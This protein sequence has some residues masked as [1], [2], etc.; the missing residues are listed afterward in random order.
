M[1]ENTTEVQAIQNST[2]PIRIEASLI[3]IAGI[4]A[5]TTID[6]P[7]KLAAV[8]FSRGC[9]WKCRYCHN[10]DLR[11]NGNGSEGVPQQELHEFLERRAGFLEGIV[12]SGGEPTLHTRLPDFLRWIRGFGYATALHTNGYYPKML[13]R[14]VRKK[15]VD[16]I[17]MDIKAPPAVYDRVTGTKNSCI[18][19]ARSIEIILASGI[20]YEFRTTYHP[21]VLSEQELMEIVRI[22]SSVGGKR[23]YLQKFRSSGVEDEELTDS[24][25]IGILPDTVVDEARRLF[26]EFDVR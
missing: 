16:Y 18:A 19:V 23:Y 20:E 2:E 4:Q 6:F 26:E 1:H 13:N 25:E 5:M 17:A 9:P 7:G 12:L 14:I 8:F 3:P 22:V 15:L 11:S 24:C 10:P 21:A